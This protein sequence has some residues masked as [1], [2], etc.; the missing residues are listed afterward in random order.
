MP[1]RMVAAGWIRGTGVADRARAWWGAGAASPWVVAATLGGVGSARP[2]GLP[3]YASPPI[4]EVA[5]GLHFSP[6][7]A[8]AEGVLGSFY[9]VVRDD[10]PGFS[11]QPRRDLPIEHLGTS[12]DVSQMGGLQVL[13]Q[14]IV[15]FAQSSAGVTGSRRVWL[16]TRDDTRLLQLQDDWFVHNWRRRQGDYPHF[17]SVFEEFQVRYREFTD[18]LR[19]TAA[20]PV[21]QPLEV[22][23]TYTNW[24][25]DLDIAEFLAPGAAGR[26]TRPDVS[27]PPEVLVW[28]AN[29]L[30]SQDAVAIARLRLSCGPAT[31]LRDGQMQRGGVF[32]LTFKAPTA[33]NITEEEWLALIGLGRVV[34][35]NSFH[36]LT[37]EMAHDHWGF[38][39]AE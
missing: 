16:S 3:D 36:D 21:L 15:T 37:T 9:Q 28:N 39:N 1:A 6:I 18:V 11:Y 8:F 2:P 7:S 4:D 30:I 19:Q 17:E 33:P 27:D 10:Y 14:A 32:M 5:I 38:I 20:K 23:V 22:E 29:Y 26:I 35:V 34:I 13:P 24:V 31:T 12:G 25:G